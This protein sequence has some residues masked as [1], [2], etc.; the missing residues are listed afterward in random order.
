[1]VDPYAFGARDIAGLV[2]VGVAIVVIWLWFLHLQGISEREPKL[3]KPKP[4]D[5]LS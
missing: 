1:M 3:A 5:Q 4:P 2:F